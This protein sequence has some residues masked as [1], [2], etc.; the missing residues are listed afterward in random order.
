MLKIVEGV[1][2]TCKLGSE[3]CMGHC[4]HI[5]LPLPVFNPLLVDDL[6]KLL[7]LL[8]LGCG[9]LQATG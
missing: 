7:S 1:C 3:H 5:E 9:K 4:G 6:K 8:C 2:G